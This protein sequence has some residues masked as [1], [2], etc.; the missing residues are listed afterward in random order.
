LREPSTDLHNPEPRLS[1]SASH[2]VDTQTEGRLFR[3]DFAAAL[4]GWAGHNSSGI[5][6]ELEA[7]SFW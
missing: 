6:L 2:R 5:K 1:G 7:D 4:C 3:P